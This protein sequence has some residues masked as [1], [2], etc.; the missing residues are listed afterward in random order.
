VHVLRLDRLYVGPRGLD[1]LHQSVELGV[2]RH[3]NANEEA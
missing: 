3:I 1:Q 2:I